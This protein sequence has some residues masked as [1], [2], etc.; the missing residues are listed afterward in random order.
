MKIPNAFSLPIFLTVIIT[1]FLLA[2]A[3][4]ASPDQLNLQLTACEHGQCHATA[5]STG[6]R[7]RHCVSEAG[8]RFCWQHDKDESINCRHGRCQAT[9]TSTDKQCKRCV[10]RKGYLFCYQHD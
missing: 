6:E 8:D 2:F 7:C 1:A 10:S 4:E 3:P 5:T 9:A